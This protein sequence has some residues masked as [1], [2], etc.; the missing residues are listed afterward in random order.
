MPKRNRDPSLM[1][2]LKVGILFNVPA[3]P[4]SDN[5]PEYV[6]DAEIEDQVRAVQE[7]LKNLTLSIGGSPLKTTLKNSL[8]R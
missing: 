7:T 6:A 8:N 2:D 3:K 5:E 4:P 1:G